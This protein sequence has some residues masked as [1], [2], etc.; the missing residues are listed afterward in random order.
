MFRLRVVGTGVVGSPY[1]SNFY[2][3]GIDGAGAAA[4]L[5][6]LFDGFAPFQTQFLVNT[7]EPEAVSI[8]PVNGQPIAS[9]PVTSWTVTGLSTN[10]ILPTQVQ[11]L[12]KIT[13][14]EYVDGRQIQGRVN[15]AG[16]T[17][18][19]QNNGAFMNPATV[20]A[21]QTEWDQFLDADET[22]EWDY[23]V[24]S[25]KNG[26]VFPVTAATVEAAWATLRSRGGRG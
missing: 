13:T 10:D 1:Y 24:Y 9:T 12:T 6:G 7:L 8:N 21:L 5:E 22:G 17:E 14:G 11:A 25:R 23:A 18:S 19:S 26:A 20:D 16:L 3:D 2:F 15:I 4:A